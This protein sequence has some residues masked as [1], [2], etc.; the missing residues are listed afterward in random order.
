MIMILAALLSGIGPEA[1][2]ILPFSFALGYGM[3]RR[4]AFLR[5]AIVVLEALLHQLKA[6]SGESNPDRCSL[7]EPAPAGHHHGHAK[8]AR[9][10]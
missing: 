7:F 9:L 2:L 1:V 8:G 10:H 3:H 6:V 4:D 5:G